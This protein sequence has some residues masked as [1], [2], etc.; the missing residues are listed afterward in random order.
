MIQGI[1]SWRQ[2]SVGLHRSVQTARTAWALAWA[3]I[4]GLGLGR[5]RGVGFALFGVWGVEVIDEFMSWLFGMGDTEF[6][7]A[8]LG[9]QHD[10]LA[11]QAAD[12]VEGSAGLAAQRQFQEV[13][14]DAGLKGFLEFGLDL[15]EPIG[16]TK[17]TDALM[18]PA[19]IVVSDPEFDALPGGLEALELGAG[20]EL[21]PDRGPEPLDFAQGHGV[22]GA[23]LEMRD[24]VFL[25]L[26]LEAADPAPVGVLAAVVGEHLFGGLVFADGDAVDLDHGGGGGAAEQVRA[27]DE[28]GVIVQEA[29]EVG[30]AAAQPEGEDV[31]LPHLVGGGPFE[32]AGPGEVPRPRGSSRRHQPGLMQAGTNR[33]GARRQQEEP[34]QELR[35]PLH[36]EAGVSAFECEDLLGDGG[37]ELLPPGGRR[38]RRPQPRFPVGSVALDPA[39]Q[40]AATNAQLV[41]D[42]VPTVAFLQNQANRFEFLLGR[43]TNGR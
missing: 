7:L 17:A 38:R 35:N 15:E 22:M 6:E 40:A 33:L 3:L 23:A 1:W 4:G 27:H 12:Q 11:F 16:R 18:G 39:L 20:Q 43:V 32:K 25:E 36:A 42:E 21:A 10:R 30:V 8:F 31:R 37:G 5:R 34:A 26:G 24:P 2:T 41:T 13:V 28:A 9:A 29:N 19:V 14:L